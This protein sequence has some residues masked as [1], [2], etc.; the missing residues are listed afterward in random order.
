MSVGAAPRDPARRRRWGDA[1][2]RRPQDPARARAAAQVARVP[3]RFRSRP[4]AR[5]GHAGPGP[6]PWFLRPT[7]AAGARRTLCARSVDGA[8]LVTRGTA[9]GTT[10]GPRG[11]RAPSPRL[12]AVIVA[13]AE[14][15]GVASP[16]S[17]PI[18]Q[19]GHS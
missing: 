2:A 17:R 7:P 9:L 19:R 16:A 11:G 18:G 10:P 4:Q 3:A 15:G 1:R 5:A 14:R 12:H 6:T 13:R 8:C